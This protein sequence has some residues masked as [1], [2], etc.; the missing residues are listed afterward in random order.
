MLGGRLRSRVERTP[1][2]TVGFQ[3]PDLD[4]C[5]PCLAEKLPPAVIDSNSPVMQA[6][7]MT[8]NTLPASSVVAAQWRGGSPSVEPGFGRWQIMQRCFA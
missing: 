2:I 1:R 6:G 7:Q 8:P 4:S 3:R 5:R